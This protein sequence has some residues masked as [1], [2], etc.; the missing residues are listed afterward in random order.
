MLIGISLDEVGR[1]K[2]ADVKWVSHRWPLIE[3]RM[4]RTDC[5][6]WLASRGH[7]AVP[8]SSCAG[9]PY[10]SD[11]HWLDM[12]ENDPEAWTDAV[13]VD[14]AVRDIPSI[15][16]RVYL[17][18]SGAPLEE[19]DF[20]LRLRLRKKESAGQLALFGEEGGEHDCTGMCF[21]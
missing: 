12:K 4:T 10:H 17:H 21:V 13:E 6:A 14:R 2:P 9:C 16:G 8:R 7:T 20:Q 11:S 5:L 15:R 19:V 18:R 3:K 1:M